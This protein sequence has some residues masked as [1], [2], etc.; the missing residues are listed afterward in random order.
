[1]KKIINYIFIILV[2]IFLIAGLRV[3]DTNNNLYVLNWGDY[4]DQEL[5]TAFEEKY[6]V[7]VL[8]TEVESNEAMYE[9]IKTNRTAFDIAIPSDYMIEQLEE[10][11]LLQDIEYSKLENYSEGMFNSLTTSNGPDTKNYIP[12]FNGTIGIMYSTKNVENIEEIVTK[13]GWNVFFDSSLLENANIAMYNSS[14]DAFAA[15]MFYNNLDIDS[16]NINDLQTAANSLSH[17]KYSEF[18]DD[19]LKTQVVSG[20]IDVALVYSGDYYLELT[21]ALDEE[22]EVDF[23]YYV[24]KT[25]N[26]W[27]DGMVI[28][29][30][31]KNTDLAYKFIDFMLD[32]DNAIQNTQYIG[33]ASPQINVMKSLNEDEEYDFLMKDPF[34]DPTTI[35]DLDPHSYHFLGFQY[36]STLEEMF[37]KIKGQ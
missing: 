6:D 33:Y 32:E 19:N 25:T 30:Q 31:S 8:M 27:V 12:Y 5:I 18:G 3:S 26:Y 20:N 17:M 11:K 1:M 16:T 36:M 10:E 9:Q 29:K 2:V 4:I 37:S 35:K 14:R 7:K 23:K 34:F 13:E 24:P 22:R 15:S 28:P 21:T